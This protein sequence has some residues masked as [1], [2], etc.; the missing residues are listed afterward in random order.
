MSK[1]TSE[2][3]NTQAVPFFA[4]FLEAQPVAQVNKETIKY[5]SDSEEGAETKKYPSDWEED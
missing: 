2:Q 3:S 4:R 1:N 5:P